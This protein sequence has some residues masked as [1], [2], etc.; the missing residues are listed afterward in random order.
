MYVCMCLAVKESDITQA[1][2]EGSGS[3]EDVQERTLAGTCCGA[4]CDAIEELVAKVI[5]SPQDPMNATPT[6]STPP[7]DAS[8]RRIA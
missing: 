3:L 4:C 7:P 1:V 8:R 5:A 2:H 6:I